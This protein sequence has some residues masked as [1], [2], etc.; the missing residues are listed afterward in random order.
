MVNAVLFD[1]GGVILKEEDPWDVLLGFQKQILRD[2]GYRFTNQE[3]DAVF[4]DCLLSFVPGIYS[5]ITWAFTKPDVEKCKAITSEVMRKVNCWLEDHPR[6]IRPEI[7]DVLEQLHG[8]CTLALAGNASTSI[9]D[10]LQSFDVLRYFD[11]TE[12]SADYGLSKPDPRLLERILHK[13]NVEPQHAV[14]IGDRLDNDILPAKVLGM[15]T[16][17]LKAGVYR[18]LEPR[19]PS[20]IPDATITSVTEIPSVIAAL[21]SGRGR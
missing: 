6:E 7:H 14:M 19:N 17:L 8:K 5:A 21:A 4:K 10:V 18:I 16:I 9:K 11:H 20:E 15:K 2:E 1:I 13:C 3:F 12:V